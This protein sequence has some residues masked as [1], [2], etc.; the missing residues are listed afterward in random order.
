MTLRLF[1]YSFVVMLAV[2]ALAAV[3]QAGV[4]ELVP[5]SEVGDAQ[6]LGVS[7]DA[8]AWVGEDGSVGECFADNGAVLSEEDVTTITTDDN[9][10][11]EEAEQMVYVSVPPPPAI[12]SILMA[13]DSQPGDVNG[14]GYVNQ[15]DVDILASN[16]QY[17]V[18]GTADATREMGDLNGDG[19][20]DGSD[21]TILADNW[22]ATPVPEP[23]TIMLLLGGIVS[24]ILSRRYRKR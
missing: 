16:W 13:P 6:K 2:A 11:F 1:R 5:I 4:L 19:M 7:K 15:S 17:G 9:S 3:T 23:S 22:G 24:L 12:M 18:T 10:E 21:V 8:A 20:V 14:D